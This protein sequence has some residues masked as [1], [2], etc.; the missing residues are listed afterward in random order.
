MKLTAILLA[1][2]S[3]F[4]FAQEE[5]KPSHT[6]ITNVTIFDGVNEQTTEGSVLIEDNLIKEVGAD[7]KTPEGA[8]VIDGGG[9][10]LMPGLIDSHVHFYLSM[11][12]GRP[13]METSRWDYFPAMG[14][15]A[16]QE[17]LADG[18]TTVRD[19]G[20]M[21]DGLRRVVDAG[22]LDG[23]RMYLAAGM[24]TQSS[25]HGDMLPEGKEASPEESN[26]V[27][28]GITL[29]A[30]GPDEVRKAVRQNFSRG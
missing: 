20:G 15:V 21:H 7:V 30:D 24:V 22:L 23:P 6:H 14:A 17:W 4:S 12:G 3:P 5:E 11:D 28:L 1:A 13:G 19:M 8:T 27:K 16:A 9:K 18:F 2:L 29:I 26:L 10:F 25:G